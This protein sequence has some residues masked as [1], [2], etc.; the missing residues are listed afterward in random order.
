MPS[1]VGQW[2]TT[3]YSGNDPANPE[4]IVLTITE[5]AS[6]DNLDGAYARPGQDARMFGAL[7]GGGAMWRATIDERNSSGDEGSAL[8]FISADGQTLFGAWSSQQHN[9]GPQPWFG[10]RI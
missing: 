7:E 3:R 1:F 8:F 10:T 6:P 9:N 2:Q 5:D 4:P